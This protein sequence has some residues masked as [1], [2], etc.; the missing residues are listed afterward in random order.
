[1]DDAGYV[2]SYLGLLEF[3]TLWMPGA[4]E[5]TRIQPVVDPD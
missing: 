3:M 5:E 2:R 1:M 4:E